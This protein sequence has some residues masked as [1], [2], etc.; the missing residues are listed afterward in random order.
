MSV[1]IPK[2]STTYRYDFW[3]KGDRYEGTTHQQRKDDAELAEAKIKLGLRRLSII[4]QRAI[5]TNSIWSLKDPVLPRA[6][7]PKDFSVHR[8]WPGKPK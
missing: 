3:F 4:C 7:P 6:Q 8:F 5:W 2:G 1:Y